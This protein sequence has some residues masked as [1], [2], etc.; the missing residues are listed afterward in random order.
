MILQ[1]TAFD[2]NLLPLEQVVWTDTARLS[3]APCFRGSRVP[4]K[5]LFDYLEG[6]DRL[7]DFLTDFEGVR[8]EQALAAL[9]YGKARLMP[10]GVPQPTG[11]ASEIVQ[12][13]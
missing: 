4:V 11:G 9:Y 7:N 12:G 2:S 8:R 1:T 6:G 13:R 3:G 5:A 10:P